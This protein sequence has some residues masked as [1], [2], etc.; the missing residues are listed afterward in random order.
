MRLRMGVCSFPRYFDRKYKT[1]SPLDIRMLVIRYVSTIVWINDQN[2]SL[3]STKSARPIRR[4]IVSPCRIPA[5][6]RRISN[7]AD[8]G[9]PHPFYIATE[10]RSNDKL[11]RRGLREAWF[12]ICIAYGEGGIQQTCL[13]PHRAGP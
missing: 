3:T 2:R 11:K 12:P 10:F 9:Q 4:E 8:I 6:S 1:V 13:P 7:F 5:F